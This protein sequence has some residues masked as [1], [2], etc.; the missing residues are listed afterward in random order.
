MN[1]TDLLT[2]ANAALVAIILVITGAVKSIFSDFFLSSLGQRL[3]PLLPIV[4]GVGLSFLG[5]GAATTVV[6]KIMVGLLSGLTAAMSFKLG[7]TSVLGQ[8]IED[9]SA[10]SVKTAKKEK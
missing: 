4:L 1:P 2:G 8:G 5:L 6:D 9:K 10:K 7:K 3:L